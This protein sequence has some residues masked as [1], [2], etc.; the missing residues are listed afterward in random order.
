[1]IS[2][3]DMPTDP[4][5]RISIVFEKYG[6]DRAAEFASSWPED[7]QA[8]RLAYQGYSE[9]R[10]PFFTKTFIAFTRLFF[11]CEF[12][13]LLSDGYKAYLSRRM[14]FRGRSHAKST[15]M[16]PE[17]MPKRPEDR[18]TSLVHDYPVLAASFTDFVM[19]SKKWRGKTTDTQ[20][21][22]FVRALLYGRYDQSLRYTPLVLQNLVITHFGVS[23]FEDILTKRRR[24]FLSSKRPR[25][26]WKNVDIGRIRKVGELI[27]GLKADGIGSR[28][29]RGVIIFEAENLEPITVTADGEYKYVPRIPETASQDS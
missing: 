3:K 19:S 8:R 26:S 12:N 5:S 20:K 10:K 22:M 9:G 4:N 28:I 1:M 29:G 15:P 7:A 16:K 21:S 23:K 11:G 14:S 6:K 18:L 25:L 24:E 2:E 17:T 27:A 13:D